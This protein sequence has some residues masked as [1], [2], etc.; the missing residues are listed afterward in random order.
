[1]KLT[2]ENLSQCHFVHHKSDMDGPGIE[3]GP[4]I[5][6]LSRGKFVCMG[7]HYTTKLRIPCNAFYFCRMAVLFF[8]RDFHL[9]SVEAKG[10]GKPIRITTK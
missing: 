7:R 1:M 4:P 8:V 3:P 10:T 2:G 5:V 9:V 6:M